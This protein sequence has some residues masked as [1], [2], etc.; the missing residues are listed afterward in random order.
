MNSM[1]WKPYPQERP[2]KGISCLVTIEY[3]NGRLVC[4]AMYFTHPD[5]DGYFMLC[6][7]DEW[8]VMPNVIAWMAYP[9]PYDPSK[10]E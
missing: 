7:G 10:G 4:E 9:K 6:D 3:E 1:N 2:K 8:N 5:G